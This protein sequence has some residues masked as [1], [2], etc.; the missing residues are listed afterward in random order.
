M[1]VM[2]HLPPAH[3]TNGFAFIIFDYVLSSTNSLMD[4]MSI[5]LRKFKKSFPKNHRL[6]EN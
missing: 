1:V 5:L 2:T 4:I 6:W 3:F